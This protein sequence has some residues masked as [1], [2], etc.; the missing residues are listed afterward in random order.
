[1]PAEQTSSLLVHRIV[2]ENGQAFWETEINLL[3]PGKFEKPP[4]KA[5]ENGQNVTVRFRVWP[6]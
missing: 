3:Y 4:E 1:L 5:L 6:P 2:E